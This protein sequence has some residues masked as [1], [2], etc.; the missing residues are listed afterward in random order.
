MAKKQNSNNNTRYA[1]IGLWIS[2]ISFIAL[3][4]AGVMKAF[5]ATGFYTPLDATLLPR[6]LW[7][8][9][10]G[11]FIGLGIFALLDPKRILTFLAGRQAKYGSNALIT[12][13]AFIAI[14]ILGNILAYQNP[15]QFDWTEENRNTLAPESIEALDALPQ[16]VKATA[17]FS[18]RFN[19]D[20]TRD[21]LEK[22][23]IN[24]K[25]KFEFEFV[26]PDR[27]PIAA[28]NAGITGDGRI[29]LEMGEAREIVTT[30]NEQEITNGFIK[31]LNPEKTAVYFLSGEGEHSIDENSAS[32][33]IRIRQA[34][35][36]K[37]Y[38]VN[39]LNLE[40][41]KI[42]DDAKVIVLAG[43]INPL[44]EQAVEALKAYLSTGGSLVVLE[45]PVPLTNFGEKDDLLADY[46][47]IEWGIT[48]NNDIIVDTEAPSSAYNA[49]ALQYIQHPITEK[50]GG[51]GITLPYARS[52]TVSFELP[53]VL[54]TDLIYTT[55][56]AWGETDFASIEAGQPAFDPTT[57]LAGPML[58]AATAENTTTGARLVVTGNSSFAIDDNFDF[59]GNGDFLINS[60][61]WGAEKEELIALSSVQPTERT[62]VAPGAFQRMI[63][64]ATSVCLI[65]LAII[66]MGITSWYARRKQG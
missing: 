10:A 56:Q 26:D 32:S 4:V 66:I 62:F 49:T 59:A 47:S 13:I 27:N 3:A 30:A 35:E 61:D 44:S 23:R 60:I 34:L 53:N 7:G 28:Q 40:A 18:S 9:L 36:N 46:L 14:L 64:L 63:M 16:Q 33:Y 1:V 57:E 38:S 37:N 55:D 54:V 22:Y 2:I 51:V 31:L 20:A 65:P 12:S 17:F 24:S 58:L 6:L 41:E 21:L 48:L 11:I 25:G 43:P 29:L 15:I 8:S 52:L 19:T 39:S 50:M 5:E 42:P 45:N